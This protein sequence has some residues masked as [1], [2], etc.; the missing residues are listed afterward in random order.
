[1]TAESLT[2]KFSSW[3]DQSKKEG[4]LK[5]WRN[6]AHTHTH[7][8]HSQIHAHTHTRQRQRFDLFMKKASSTRRL[9]LTHTNAQQARTGLPLVFLH[10]HRRP[11]KRFAS[12]ASAPSFAPSFLWL[13]IA[14]L[15]KNWLL[16]IIFCSLLRQ[17][18]HFISLKYA[19]MI[20]ALSILRWAFSIWLKFSLWFQTAINLPTPRAP[21]HAHR[22]RTRLKV[23]AHTYTEQEDYWTHHPLLGPARMLSAQRPKTIWVPWQA[24]TSPEATHEVNGGPN[25][26]RAEPKG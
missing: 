23:S 17:F 13:F 22:Q 14:W 16:Y 1:M 6:S 8:A 10:S 20:G 9:R 12:A 26:R 2:V 24:T 4:N 11:K 25:V 18:V 3:L 15:Y 21:T 7:T 5:A 19:R